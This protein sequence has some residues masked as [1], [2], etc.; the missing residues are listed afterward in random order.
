MTVKVWFDRDFLEV[1]FQQSAGYLRATAHES[2][3]ARVDAEGN[4]IGFKSIT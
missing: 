2:F 3:M 4:I 1:Q